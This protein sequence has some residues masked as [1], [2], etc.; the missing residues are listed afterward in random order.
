MVRIARRGLAKLLGIAGFLLALVGGA[1]IGFSALTSGGLSV[2][3]M[4]VRMLEVLLGLGAMIAGL[5]MYT[6][7]LR[8]GGILC[9]LAGTLL[10]VLTAF[11][12][13]AMLVFTGG[14]LGIVGAALKPTWWKF[15]KR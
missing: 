15:W 11:A 7:P 14:V 8:F 1:L 12:T 9:V 5:M 13:P 6:G 4:I 3:S 2:P 10:L